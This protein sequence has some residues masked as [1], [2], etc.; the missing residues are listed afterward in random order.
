MGDTH[1]VGVCIE[2]YEPNSI[3]TFELH[4]RYTG[5]PDA[6][7]P[8]T[9]NSAETIPCGATDGETALD[10]SACLDANP[11]AND[12]AGTDKLGTGW[13]CTSL[14]LQLPLGEDPRRRAWP[15]RSLCATANLVSPDQELTADPGLLATITFTANSAG[16]DVIDFGPI[17]TSNSNAVGTPRPNGG[18]ARCSTAVAADQVACF[19]ATVHKRPP[20]DCLWQDDTGRGTSLCLA[21]QNWTFSYP[22]GVFGGTGRVMSLL[23]HTIMMGHGQGF[24]AWAMGTCPSGPGSGVAF[25]FRS[26]P[27]QLLHL[28]DMTA[29]MP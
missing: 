9:L 29:T 25:D 21:G 16:D 19:G 4:I 10:D 24:F 14:G 6:D 27:P 2:T 28:R 3:G 11:D 17:D 15:T 1:Q 12:G 5:D 18:F 22:Q 7:P 8:T 13:D 23:N 26:L 20:C